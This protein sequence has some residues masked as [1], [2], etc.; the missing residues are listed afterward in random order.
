MSATQQFWNAW[1]HMFRF[2]P[3]GDPYIA[4]IALVVVVIAGLKIIKSV[5]D[6]VTYA[7]VCR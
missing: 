5:Y 3:E 4:A 6:R 1:A 7:N 2:L